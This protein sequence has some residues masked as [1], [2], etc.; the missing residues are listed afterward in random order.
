MKVALIADIHANVRA[1]E[2]VEAALDRWR[3]D[4]VVVLGD[5]VNRGPQPAECLRVVQQRQREHGWQVIVGNHEEYVI[6]LASDPPTP[7]SP[8]HAV[9][10]HT[11]WTATTLSD[12]LLADLRQLPG[13]CRLTTPAGEARFTHGSLLGSRDGVYPDTTDEELSEKVDQS[14]SLFG[15]GHTHRPLLRQLGTTRVANAGSVGMPFDGDHRPAYIRAEA[16]IQGW[17][18]S[19]ERLQYD[20]LAAARAYREGPFATGSGHIGR[21][22]RRE[23]DLARPLL[24]DWTRQYQRA[25]LTSELSMDHAVERFLATIN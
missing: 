17:R 6:S 9:H 23:F 18:L 21:V 15:V 20:W 2:A 19:V 25:V 12:D 10:R 1:L 8:Q 24:A 13:E 3:P 7:G 11:W 5:T 14:V 22:I 4:H 16:T